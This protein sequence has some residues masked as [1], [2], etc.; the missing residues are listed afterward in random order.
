M[1]ATIIMSLSVLVSAFVASNTRHTHRYLLLSFSII[2]VF[3][4]LRYD[5]GND[6][7][8]YSR[9]FDEVHRLSFRDLLGLTA[10]PNPLTL[11]PGYVWL[12]RIMPHFFILVACLSLFTVYTLYKF[13][14]SYLPPSVIWFSLLIYLICP[15][16][17]LIHASALRQ[18]IAI[19]FFIFSIKYLIERSFWKY[20]LILLV[21]GFFHRS[22]IVLI[23]FYFIVT[24]KTW[25]RQLLYILVGVYIFTTFFGYVFLGAIEKVTNLPMLSYYRYYMVHIEGNALDTGFGYIFRSLIFV[26]V[27]WSHDK[28]PPQQVVITKLAMIGFLLLPLSIYLV[29]FSRITMYFDVMLIIALPFAIYLQETKQL[30]VV[31]MSILALWYLYEYVSFFQDPLWAPFT[32]YKINIAHGLSF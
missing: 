6:Y 22:A 30:R 9:Y 29:I 1:I 12:N 17:L 5:F 4:A 14:D 15:S 28:C 7:M 13:T 24:P 16:F 20:F 23:P 31:L 3:L 32:H 19:C 25:S 2:L 11:E 18:T 27:L 21:A 26:F 8:T 10:N